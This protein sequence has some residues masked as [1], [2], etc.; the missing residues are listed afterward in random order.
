MQQIV[1]GSYASKFFESLINTICKQK[2]CITRVY[3]I[4][5]RQIFT[6]HSYIII[7]TDDLFFMEPEGL[8]LLL[9]IYLKGSCVQRKEENREY[10]VDMLWTVNIIIVA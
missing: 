2:I 9:V 7:C 1:R 8:R 3:Q 5:T 4:L 10:I 6:A